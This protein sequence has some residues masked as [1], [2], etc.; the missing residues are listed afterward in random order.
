MTGFSSPPPLGPLSFG[1]LSEIRRH[2]SGSMGG[3]PS[4]PP[5]R[6]CPGPLFVHNSHPRRAMF[7][8]NGLLLDAFLLPRT[9]T[10]VLPRL[11]SHQLL[12]E[13]VPL[14]MFLFLYLSHRHPF[15]PPSSIFPSWYRNSCSPAR[16][17]LCRYHP[18]FPL[19]GPF[20]PSRAFF[21][22]LVRRW[23]APL[24]RSIFPS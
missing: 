23:R 17:T 8:A 14:R 16:S 1:C 18:L 15:A 11:V 10:P 19:H 22:I 2:E 13:Y 7:S 9:R 6:F 4:P 21:R 12:L 3:F 24:P 5:L 20:I